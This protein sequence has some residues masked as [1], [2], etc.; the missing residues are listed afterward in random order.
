MILKTWLVPPAVVCA[1]GI[2]PFTYLGLPIGSNMNLVANWQIM[3][4]RFRG[5]LSTWKANMLSIGG[6]L[7]LIKAVLGSLGIYYMSIFK[8]PESVLKSLEYIW[9]SFFW[10]GS[11]DQKKMAWIKWDN[12]LAFLIK[13][14]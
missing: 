9:A 10:G 11:G 7:T 13:V 3:I 12:I 4:D 8:C 14:V 6:R 5:K 2:V 1:S